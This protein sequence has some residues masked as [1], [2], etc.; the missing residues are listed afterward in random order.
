MAVMCRKC[1]H[2]VSNVRAVIM[3]LAHIV[4]GSVNK[5]LLPDVMN[6]KEIK[7]PECGEVGRWDWL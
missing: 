4:F 1:S 3:I 7:C 5:T 2:E 6:A